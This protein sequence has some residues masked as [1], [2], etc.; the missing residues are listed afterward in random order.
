MTNLDNDEM[1][2]W[3]LMFSS[4]ER[5]ASGINAAH[6]TPYPSVTT[7]GAAS[8]AEGLNGKQSASPSV[9]HNP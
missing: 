5:H 8:P 7:A 1:G 9:L 6:T 2:A 3:N 4:R